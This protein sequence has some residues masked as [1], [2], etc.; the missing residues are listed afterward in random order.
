VIFRGFHSL[1]L[2]AGGDGK[3]GGGG[4]GHVGAPYQP[5]KGGQRIGFA[6]ADGG[7]E[8]EEDT[9]RPMTGALLRVMLYV[10][11]GFRV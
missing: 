2:A 4:G 6:T 5:K 10:P 1:A 7:E 11:Q 3:S 9:G 8:E